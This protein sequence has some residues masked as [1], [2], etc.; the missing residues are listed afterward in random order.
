MVGVDD[1]GRHIT[2]R[3]WTVCTA[4]LNGKLGR[5]EG[6]VRRGGVIWQGLYV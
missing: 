1:G 4:R 6:E 2:L 3:A 5:E